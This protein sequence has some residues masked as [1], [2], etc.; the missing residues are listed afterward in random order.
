MA[1]LTKLRLG[2]VRKGLGVLGLVLLS[3]LIQAPAAPA[4]TG[5]Q[6][7][8]TAQTAPVQIDPA[9]LYGSSGNQIFKFVG[10]QGG[11]AST[12]L[13]A[14]TAPG[15]PN[16]WSSNLGLGPDA[17]G[18][19]Q[20]VGSRYNTG[21]P[22][23]YGLKDGASEITEIG[24][25]P[26]ASVRWGGL[27]VAPDGSIW[28]GTNLQSTGATRISRFDAQAGT[29]VISGPL[30]ST[31]AGDRVWNGGGV[32]APDYAFDGAGNLF[33]LAF[34]GGEGWIYRY[35][36]DTFSAAGMTVTP[37]LQISGPALTAG[38][39]NYGFA[40][41]GGSWYSANSNGVLFR[42]DAQTGASAVAGQV[43]TPPT[44]DYR[45]TDLASA[46]LVPDPQLVVTKVADRT[47]VDPGGVVRYTLTGTNTGAATFAA[48]FADEL[49]EVL[50]EADYN[51][52]A[53]SD[54]GSIELSGQRL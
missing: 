13:V 28:Q 14:Q 35:N 16:Y 26:Q 22:Q 39:S 38:S 2:I 11:Q 8:L 45:L 48:D 50:D 10:L 46:D 24:S 17:Q 30:Q 53:S 41:L 7:P 20:F 49:S 36:V 40:W 23:L 15:A 54:I 44:F 32:V 19:L 37:W 4:A 34:N 29:G 52:D 6:W 33:G 5:D 43:T 42:I 51:G 1:G 18:G 9:G 12:E 47:V 31:V 3:A 27:S 25:A 21:Y